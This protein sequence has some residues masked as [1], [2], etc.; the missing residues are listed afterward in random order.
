MRILL[1]SPYFPPY[2]SIGAVR[3]GKFAKYLIDNGHEVRVISAATP[4]L[5]STLPLEI[6]D[7]AVTRCNNYSPDALYIRYT[8]NRLSAKQAPSSAFDIP[9]SKLKKILVN[10]YNT[11]FCIPDRFIGWLPAARM[12]S[13]RLALEFKPDIVYASAQP[14]TALLAGRYAAK[15]AGVPFIAEFRDLWIDNHYRSLPRFRLMLDNW[16]ERRVCSDAAA[17]VTISEPLANKLAEKYKKKTYVVQNGF[18]PKDIYFGRYK[19]K[20]TFEIVY[21]G[22]IY[23][24]RRDPTLLFRVLSR[25]GASADN[26]RVR[27]FGRRLES[28]R[29]IARREG[30]DHLVSIEGELPYKNA[31]ETQA[32]ADVLLLLLWNT[33]EERGVLTGKLFEYLASRRPILLLGGGQGAAE[34]LI[35]DRGAGCAA[36]TVEVLEEQLIE[37]L[38]QH[39]DGGVP[40]LSEEVSVGLSRQDQ[41]SVFVKDLPAI[42]DAHKENDRSTYFN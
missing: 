28:V 21:T 19:K 7:Y 16:L 15:C 4:E 24:D 42:V 35:I 31:L 10:F 22:S 17:M 11:L 33:P 23:P 1:I 3:T 40:Y 27:F 12:A 30:V 26:V 34:K 6:P 25:L 29:E 20:D 13:R 9:R 18:D 8:R 36:N 2:N 39:A 5:S 14:F 38:R 41:F 32:A 37:W